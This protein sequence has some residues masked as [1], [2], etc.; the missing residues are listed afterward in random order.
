MTSD[1]T[2][3]SEPEKVGSWDLLAETL[4]VK[5]REEWERVVEKE[6]GEGGT[7]DMVVE[8][9]AVMDES[10]RK[11]A[12]RNYEKTMPV[13]WRSCVTGV[14]EVMEKRVEEKER[15]RK[16]EMMKEGVWRM[17][18]QEGGGP[19]CVFNFGKCERQTFA[20]VYFKDQSYVEWAVK[21]D[22]CRT[23]KLKAFKYFVLR[24]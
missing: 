1:E 23:W 18:F 22:K 4:R 14:W 9:M 19:N 15:T 21:Q 8:N 13:E 24:L 5:V 7:L 3:Q 11:E 10:H 20:A 2:E 17:Y 16:A 6:R 12:M